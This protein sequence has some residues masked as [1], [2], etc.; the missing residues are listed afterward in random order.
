MI[1]H[2]SIAARE[3]ERVSGVLAELMGWVAVPDAD[4]IPSAL[5]I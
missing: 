3:P 4:S 5:T 2:L 1:H